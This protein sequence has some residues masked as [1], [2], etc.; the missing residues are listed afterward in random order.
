MNTGRFELFAPYHLI[1]MGIVFPLIIIIPLLLKQFASKKGLR[2]FEIIAGIM[3]PGF[4]IS[5]VVFFLI[6]KSIPWQELLPLHLCGIMSIIS[7]VTLLA[8]DGPLRSFLV[9]IVYF[10]GI[11]GA[12]FPIIT[13]DTIYAP[14]HPMYFQTFMVHGGIILTGLYMI[15]VKGS[16][17]RLSGIIP[18][19]LFANITMVLIYP[20]NILLGTNFFFL[21]GPAENPTPIDV[22]IDIFGQPPRHLIGLEIVGII[23][24]LLVYA[25]LGVSRSISRLKKRGNSKYNSPEVYNET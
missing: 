8:G 25:P 10:L 3:L 18:A 13:P 1:T 11:G 21:Q 23:M 5:R 24:F 9:K 2:T 14:P 22:L 19:F 12:L 7:S 20:V 4:E 16:R 15:I 17:I 6:D